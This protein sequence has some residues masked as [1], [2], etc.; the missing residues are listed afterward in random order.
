MIEDLQQLKDQ[1]LTELAAA[2]DA[3]AVEAWRVK[4]LSRQG[5][6]PVFL[7]KIKT[8]PKEQRP[9]AG[10]AANL[11]KLTISDAY[12]AKKEQF[13]TVTSSA[14]EDPTLPGR[15]VPWATQHVV[16]QTIDRVVQIFRRMG[17]ALATGPEIDTEFYNFDALNT[18]ADHPAR[19]EQDTFYVDAPADRDGHRWLLRSQTSTVQIR[20]MQTQPPP[21]KIVAPGRCYRRDEI[22]ATHGVF[23]HQI[24]GLVVD[25]GIT[26][27]DLKGTM[28]YFFKEFI[29]A[30]TRV[31]FRPHFFPFTEPSFEIDMARSGATM[32]GKE[33][34]EIAGCGMVDP[35]VFDNVN[36]DSRR[37]T[38]F[39]FGM[40]V[41]RLAMLRH[42]INDLR[43]IYEN[44]LRFLSQF[45]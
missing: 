17:F 41:E 22:D 24:E 31:R 40:G 16:N 4:Y 1:A 43:L 28:E 3:D 21:I 10:K 15:P 27:A 25:D 38:G 39:A 13:S 33:W 6:L 12:E 34:L 26:L 32:K 23:F 29:G 2:A 42:G 20:A 19:N 37:Y 14:P 44:D 45:K 8:L 9:E 35:A 11:A 30:D 5:L 7:E 36:I 18:P